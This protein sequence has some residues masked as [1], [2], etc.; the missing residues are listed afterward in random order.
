MAYEKRPG[1]LAVF[2]NDRKEKETHPDYTI[3]G[4]TLDGRPMKGALWLKEGRDGKKFMAGKIEVD[5]Y[6]E[7]KSRGGGSADVREGSTQ[8]VAGRD[9]DRQHYDLNDDIPFIV[10]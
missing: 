2:K 8:S 10:W 3:T 5:E 7:N 1:D 6:A 9:R 4:L